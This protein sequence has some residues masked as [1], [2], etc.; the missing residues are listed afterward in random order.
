[1]PV[2][3]SAAAAVPTST[4]TVAPVPVGALQ[5]CDNQPL[6]SLTLLPSM[7]MADTRVGTALGSYHPG[8]DNPGVV[9]PYGFRWIRTSFA[10]DPLNWQRVE[11]TPGHYTIDAYADAA[12]S[13]YAANGITIVMNLGVGDW[14]NEPDVTRF[15]DPAEIERYGEYVRF[16]VRH[17]KDRVGYFEI[18]NEPN[19]TMAV[20]DYIRMARHVIPIIRAEA[21]TAKIVIPAAS[22]HWEFGTPGYGTAGRNVF[23]RA[24]FFGLLDS[25][26]MPLVD[27]ISWHPFYGNRADEPYYQTYP[28]LVR[29]IKAE[30]EAH[31][32]HGVYLPQE[33]TWRTADDSIDPTF[34]RES[35][36]VA[37][38]YFVRTIVTHRGL[39]TV[40]II[41]PGAF[42]WSSIGYT[43]VLLAGAEPTHLPVHVAT[44]A[45]HL[46]QYS[47]VLPDGSHLV[48][49]WTDWL[50]VDKDPGVAATVTIDGLGDRTAEAIDVVNDVSQ[51]L[52]STASG[53]AL[54]IK[55]L[56]VK[57][58][59]TFLRIG[60]WSMDGKVGR[61]Q[62]QEVGRR[63]AP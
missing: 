47:F 13:D 28:D 33:M 3:R 45:T 60:P 14:V 61:A 30:A 54:V 11:R 34:L 52:N 8:Y 25:G 27:G 59:P 12:I 43:N 31:G 32:F 23:N 10:G 35:A 41:A 4:P 38:K 48:A 62:T 19:G 50:P 18:W 53:G 36:A 22:G 37:P 55:D 44:M 6:L 2:S 21:P 42:D 63:R 16:M 17:F 15:K 51:E 26:L 40:P 39:D 5:R 49:L 7:G 56:L 24:W 46:R 57:D 58:Y 29:E 9:Y 1:M 20:A